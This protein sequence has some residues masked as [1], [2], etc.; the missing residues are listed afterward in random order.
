MSPE[1]RRE[2]IVRA[3]LPLVAE[4]GATVTTAKIARAAGIGEA[5]IFR[6]FADKDELLGAC[7]A[8]ALRPDHVMAEL[9][10]IPLEAPLATRLVEAATALRA[11]LDRMGTVLGVLHASGYHGQGRPDHAARTPT[12]DEE[13]EDCSSDL[14][15]SNDETRA[16][17][18][19]LLEPDRASLRLPP[20]QLADV[21]LGLVFSCSHST[22]SR[23]GFTDTD[24]LSVG[25]FVDLFLNGARTPTPEAP[26]PESRPPVTPT[27]EATT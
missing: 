22:Y 5:T 27:P 21:F 1:Q 19:D 11:H 13:S 12:D 8:E 7:L 20:E 14:D 4:Y 9:A 25:E 17:I 23:L 2:M 15:R 18:A 26:T 24:A 6:V 3:A 16:A 10:S